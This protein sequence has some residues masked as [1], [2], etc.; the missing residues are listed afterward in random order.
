M[1]MNVICM[2]VCMYVAF[3]VDIFNANY[4]NRH[5]SHLDVFLDL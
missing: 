1:N 4:A 2:H 5:N 3:N